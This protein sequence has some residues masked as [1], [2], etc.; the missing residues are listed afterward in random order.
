V[1][2]PI[3]LETVLVPQELPQELPVPQELPLMHPS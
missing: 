1:P 3:V 2:L